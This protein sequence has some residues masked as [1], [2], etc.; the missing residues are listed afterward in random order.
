[1]LNAINYL[2]EYNL[3]IVMIVTKRIE[4]EYNLRGHQNII[5]PGTYDTMQRNRFTHTSIQLV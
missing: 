1:M 3:M 4:M 2:H 5:H